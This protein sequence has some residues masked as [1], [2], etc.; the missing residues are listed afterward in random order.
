MRKTSERQTSA[1]S[2][3]AQQRVYVPGCKAQARVND[4][5]LTLAQCQ[6]LSA[7][8]LEKAQA[9]RHEAA[10]QE[11]AEE[12]QVMLCGVFL[13]SACFTS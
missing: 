1:L 9:A 8:V 3:R 11:L 4:Q 5:T 13:A 7:A 6:S 12:A 2:P 10:A